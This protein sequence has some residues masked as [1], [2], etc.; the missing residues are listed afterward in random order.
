ME[1][2]EASSKGRERG[3]G[4][5]LDSTRSSGQAT[6]D[7]KAEE[8]KKKGFLTSL[9]KSEQDAGFDVGDIKRSRQLLESVIKANPKH[10]PGWIAAARLE[11]YAG[12][13]V[14]ARK[15][16]QRGCDT[17]PKNEEVWLFNIYLNKENNQNAKIIAAK[18]LEVNEQSVKLWMEAVSLEHFPAGK[19]RVLRRALDFIPQSVE[20]WKEA[21]NLEETPEDARLML[22]KAV[23][24][25]PLSIELWLALARVETPDRAQA[26]INKARKTIPT[27][28]E[29]WIAAARLEE[30][31]GNKGMPK[32]I[33][34][35]AVKQLLKEGSLVKR[36]NWIEQAEI[37][38]GDQAYETC[39]AIIQCTIG[40]GLGDDDGRLDTWLE[41]GKRSVFAGKYHTARAIYK[42]CTDVFKGS[43]RA[44][45]AAADLESAHGSREDR[46][47]I[48]KE[49]TDSIP[50]S[51]EMWTARTRDHLRSQEYPEART[52][53]REAFQK[54]A[55]DEELTSSLVKLELE[56]DNVEGARQILAGSR[57]QNPTDRIYIKSAA[58]E[59]QVGEIERAFELI[60][61]GLAL[62]PKQP[63]FFMM[64]GQLF[65]AKGMVPQAR[66]AYSTGTRLCPQSI[67]LWLLLSRL[68]EKTGLTV[69]ARSILD[70][71]RL[72]N[73]KSPELWLEAVRLEL[74]AGQEAAAR[75]KMAQAQQECPH[76]G[77]LWTERIFSLEPRTQRKPR[78]IDAVKNNEN[79]PVLYT[80]VGRIFQAARGLAN[81]DT[82]FS[83]AV[84][85]DP[86]YGDGWAW[87][88]KFLL[89]YGTEEKR[90]AVL[91]AC[92]E[93]EPKHGEVWAAVAKAPENAKKGV[94]EIL[95]IVAKGLKEVRS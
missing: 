26:V 10:G 25:V 63:K 32:K 29:I 79:D 73:R 54:N 33:L 67:A 61:E 81:A 69:K 9:D 35:N 60:S 43:S 45:L 48:L 53:L 21:V 65:E 3:F 82:W 68:E 59:R 91:E 36:D 84:Q 27:S 19:K 34:T 87:W 74:R 37:A 38:E 70:R 93:A 76:S 50:N 14:A 20:V 56:A 46:R 78:A 85:L 71:A 83:K 88:W 5:F 4:V 66:E 64:K 58:F 72:A 7:P 92:R 18:A 30:S 12:K 80:T 51:R 17:C 95:D 16:I 90:A 57:A 77:I 52:V 49:A 8:E 89:Q 40:W 15:V 2:L 42:R 94:G 31:R 24:M 23:E 47:R 28:H 39:D 75:Q 44:W 86:D 41:D 6:Y 22:A 62:H 11:H 13:L 55:G 1:M